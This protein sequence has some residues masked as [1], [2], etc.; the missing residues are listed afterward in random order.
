M[1]HDLRYTLFDQVEIP[2]ERPLRA[3]YED[4]F[5]LVDLAERA[6]F[7]AIFKSEHHH[8]PLDAAPSINVYL[9]ALTQRTQ[10][11]R[12]FVGEGSHGLIQ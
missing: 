9:A 2:D 1:G 12:M 4:H 6:G 8:V 11:L 5:E 3:V 10:R 7:D